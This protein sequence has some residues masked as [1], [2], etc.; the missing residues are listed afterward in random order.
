MADYVFENLSGISQRSRPPVACVYTL[1]PLLVLQ[2]LEPL[3]TLIDIARGVK[4]TTQHH[5]FA[6]VNPHSARQEYGVGHASPT[7]PSSAGRRSADVCSRVRKKSLCEGKIRMN[8]R[9]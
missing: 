4:Q 5:G 6:F 3:D 8:R 7:L 1:P 2:K 9:A